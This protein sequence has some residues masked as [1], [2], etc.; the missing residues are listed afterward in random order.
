MAANTVYDGKFVIT[1]EGD[2]GWHSF[3][4]VLDIELVGLIAIYACQSKLTT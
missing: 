3:Y 4:L 1:G 2:N